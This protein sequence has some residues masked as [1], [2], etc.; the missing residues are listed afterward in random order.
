MRLWVWCWAMLISGCYVGPSE[1]Q[2]G[3]Y[4]GCG[5]EKD[6]CML[7]AATAAQIQVCDARG[8]RCSAVCE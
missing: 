6:A 8:S 5:R 7:A 4:Q 1:E 3:C 2:L